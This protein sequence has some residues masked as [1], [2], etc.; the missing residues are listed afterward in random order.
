MMAGN[1]Y[2]ATHMAMNVSTHCWA[3]MD[4]M[5]T[6]SSHLVNLSTMVNRKENPIADV[7]IGPTMSMCAWVNLLSGTGIGWMG[8]AG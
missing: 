3:L 5:G 8:A 6:A 4:L 7:G 1:P 2:L